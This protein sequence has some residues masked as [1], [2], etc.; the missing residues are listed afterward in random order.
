VTIDD[1]DVT[2]STPNAIVEAGLALVPEG[3]AI[4]G[5]LTVHENLQLGAYGPQARAR[6]DERLTTV[7]DL[8]PR[9]AERRHQIARTMSGGEQQM[10][11]IGRALMSNPKIL[12]LDEPSLGLSPLLCAE[13]FRTLEEIGESG[14]GILLVEQNARLS[15]AMADRAYLVENGRIVGEGRAAALA[16]DPAVQKAYLGGALS[17]ASKRFGESEIA[18]PLAAATLRQTP[19][20]LADRAA[21]IQRAHIEGQRTGG[22][23]HLN[24]HTARFSDHPT[25]TEPIIVSS[26][27][28]D[29]SRTA[30]DMARRAAEILAQ[31]VASTRASDEAMHAAAVAAPGAAKGKKDK[32]KRNQKSK[33]AKR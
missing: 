4:F 25:T 33:K 32:K 20:D 11:A 8:F 31:H 5:D 27:A 21:R 2:A 3:R 19:A 12:M 30:A 18:V 10:V 26:Q 17:S 13:L 9:L 1:V 6:G 29:L 16:D 14:V 22:S 28:A 7:L 23:G 15:L 24:G